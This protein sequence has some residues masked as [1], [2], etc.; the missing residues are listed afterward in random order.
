MKSIIKSS[1]IASSKPVLISGDIDIFDGRILAKKH[2]LINARKHLQHTE[3]N[4][5]DKTANDDSGRKIRF[6]DD[7]SHASNYFGKLD[8]ISGSLS[9]P[10]LNMLSSLFFVP[11]AVFTADEL[12]D[13]QRCDTYLKLSIMSMD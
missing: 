4:R 6:A 5:Q 3:Q 2:A 12:I 13:S 8:L 11:C 7:R 9:R 1:N 10:F